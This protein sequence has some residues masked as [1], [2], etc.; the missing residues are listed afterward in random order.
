[1]KL[2]D[3]SS[4]KLKNKQTINLIQLRFIPAFVLMEFCLILESFNID[5]K[6]CISDTEV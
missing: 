5:L 3:I 4:V 2:H 6:L 1:M